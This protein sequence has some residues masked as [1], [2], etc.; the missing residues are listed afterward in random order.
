MYKQHLKRGYTC[1]LTVSPRFHGQFREKDPRDDISTLNQVDT[2]Y[3]FDTPHVRIQKIVD[4][5][6]ENSIR[7]LSVSNHTPA[8]VLPKEIFEPMAT[9]F[10]PDIVYSRNRDF[11]KLHFT[12]QVPNQVLAEPHKITVSINDPTV[13]YLV[14]S[15]GLISY[16]FSYGW[17]GRLIIC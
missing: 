4:R 16:R 8:T 15:T 9:I 14:V 6:S 12:M 13:F 1:S 7:A 3:H 10:Q 17:D 11:G 5:W 2:V